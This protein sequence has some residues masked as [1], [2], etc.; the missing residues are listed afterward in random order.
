MELQ[1]WFEIYSKVKITTWEVGYRN[2]EVI[3][4]WIIYS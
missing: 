4:S 3:S 2:R 1:K